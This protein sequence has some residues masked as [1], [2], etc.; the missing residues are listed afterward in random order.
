[1]Y[2]VIEVAALQ[3]KVAEGEII[4]APKLDN[5]VGK[6]LELDKV[7]CVINGDDVTVGTP[8]LAGAKVT[9]EVVRQFRDTK[10]V[11]FT[12]RK[13]KD[14]RKTIGHRQYLTALKITKISA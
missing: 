8:Y 3:F 2:A 5:E 12:Y 1:M 14:S 7:L 4:D 11:N 9:A 10:D 6:T 13:R